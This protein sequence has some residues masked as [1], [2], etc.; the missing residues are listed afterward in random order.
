MLSSTYIYNWYQWLAS[1]MFIQV[2]EAYSKRTPTPAKLEVIR[3]ESCELYVD[4]K[5]K[6]LIETMEGISWGEG[7]QFQF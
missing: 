6:N 2:W 1:G 4:N 3:F 5:G 7:G